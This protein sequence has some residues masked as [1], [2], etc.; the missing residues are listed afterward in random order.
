MSALPASL[1]VMRTRQEN[2]HETSLR[3]S[4]PCLRYYFLS[5]LLQI[6]VVLLSLLSL[7]FGLLSLFSS[8]RS[9]SRTT[10]RFTSY[11]S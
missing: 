6:F 3:I 11:A 8:T 1:E 10:A 5:F 7:F 9:C 2:R 4:K